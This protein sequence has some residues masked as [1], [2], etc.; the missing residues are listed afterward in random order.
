MRRITVR[1]IRGRLSRGKAGALSKLEQ[2]RH[3]RRRRGSHSAIGYPDWLE[4]RAGQT[5][6][7]YPVEWRGRADLQFDSPSTIA[8]LVHVYYPELLEQIIDRLAC[9]PVSYDLIITNASGQPIRLSTAATPGARHVAVLDVDNH[10]RDIWPM[11][12][13]V[14][15][16][17]LNSYELVLKLHTKRSAWRAEHAELSGD[18]EEWRTNLLDSLLG[19]KRQVERLLSAFAE[20][21]NL[22]VI[23][24]PGNVLGPEFWGGD[25][26][27]TTELLRRIEL[28]LTPSELQFPAGSFYWTRAFVLQGLRALAMSREDF[29]LEAGQVDGTT[30]HAVERSI[31]VLAAE[32]GL[33]LK[34][35][36]D[37]TVVDAD[38]WA[39]YGFGAVR[40]GRARVVPFYLPQ[41]HPTPENDAW[42]GTGFTEWTNVTAAQPV[43]LG[44]NQPNLPAD[45]GFYDLRLDAVRAAQ[46]DMAAR[47]GIEGFMY[48]YYWFAGKRL[49]S[50]PIESLSTGEVHKPF[51]LMW[52][53]ENWTRRWDGRAKDVL[54]AQDYEHV[55][56]EEFIE[57]VMPF[58]ADERYI[59]VA[60]RPVLAIYRSAQIPQ[61][62][63][64]FEHW[65]DRARQAGLGELLLLGVD[66]AREFD[67]LTGSAKAAGLDGM[68]GFPPHNQRWDWVSRAGRQVDKRFTGNLL[69]YRAMA[70]DAE[71]RMYQLA[72]SDQPAVMVTFDN[73]ARRQ[74]NSDVWVGSNPYTFRRW[75]SAAVAAVADRPSDARLVF[76]N[77]WNEWAEGAVLEPSLRFGHTYL[78]AVADVVRG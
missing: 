28:R 55:P 25:Q 16:G 56:A 52:A 22:G 2:A 14:N 65:R 19:S 17:L 63:Q 75:L 20:D 74:W 10:G 48:Y 67:G 66:V 32:A 68:L 8:V 44:H 76:V 46:M 21:P 58:L 59:R 4:R 37:L 47:Y 42:W 49:L 36:D 71:R 26:A 72:D 6:V 27:N 23:A 77:A 73:T 13:V 38:G 57:D 1:A 51:C 18:G 12:Q 54:I 5:Q 64:V 7:D 60:G 53:N 29:E 78:Q 34:A 39:R 31:G 45:L 35:S 40:T 9:I 43:Y 70:R 50:T 30:A 69:S 41:F 15:S 11:I 24:A 61:Y 62:E 33:T 3:A